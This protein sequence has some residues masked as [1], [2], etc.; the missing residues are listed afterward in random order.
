[1]ASRSDLL[2]HKA[3]EMK[4]SS[5]AEMDYNNAVSDIHRILSPSTIEEPND[6]QMNEYMAAHRRLTQAYNVILD[7]QKKI[8]AI[9]KELKA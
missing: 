8:R 2:I 7:A 1:M 3:E 4:K 6:E 9:D 5:N